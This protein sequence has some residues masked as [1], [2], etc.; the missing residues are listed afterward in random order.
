MDNSNIQIFGLVLTEFKT[1]SPAYEASALPSSPPRPSH[2]HI[3]NPIGMVTVDTAA[4]TNHMLPV[5]IDPLQPLSARQRTL[6]CA[7]CPLHPQT[8]LPTFRPSVPP[9]R[10]PHT[11]FQ[12]PIHRHRRQQ[13]SAQNDAESCKPLVATTLP[14]TRF[15]I[16]SVGRSSPADFINITHTHARIV[17][18][19]CTRVSGCTLCGRKKRRP[20][21][22]LLVAVVVVVIAVPPPELKGIW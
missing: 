20:K 11:Q 16:A 3:G 22:L 12:Y 17:Y 10:D 5:S 19:E 1:K 14:R 9:R 4:L 13:E 18:A 6:Q 8:P 21:P 7:Q 15:V 2:L